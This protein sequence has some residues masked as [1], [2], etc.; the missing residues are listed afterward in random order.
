MFLLRMPNPIQHR[1]I[2]T[3]HIR[4]VLCLAQLCAHLKLRND[5]GYN[6]IHLYE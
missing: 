2:G 5:G 3:I 4:P 6:A 1:Q